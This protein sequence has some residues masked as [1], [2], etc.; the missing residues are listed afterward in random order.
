MC[1]I[2]KETLEQGSFG[3]STGLE[4]APGSYAQTLELIELSKTVAQLNGIYATH[5]RDEG[6]RLIEAVDE[7]LTIGRDAKVSVQISHLK[8]CNKPYWNKIDTVLENIQKANEAGIQVRADRYPY[9][10]YS[11]GLSAFL[12]LWSRQGTNDEILA[13]LTKNGDAVKIAEYA[14]SRSESIGGWDRILISNCHTDEG[15]QWEGKTILDGIDQTG[16]APFEFIRALLLQERLRVSIVGFAMSE[17]NLKK[18]L[19]Y[20]LMMIGSDGNAIAPYGLLGEGKPHPRSYGTFARVLGKYCREEQL[21]DIATAVRKMTSMPA[22]KIGLKQRGVIQKNYFADITIFNPDTVI[23]N[24]TY[25]N[26]HQ[27]ASGIEY[28]IV[29]G[30]IAILK[31]EHTGTTAGIVLRRG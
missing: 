10:A 13:R 1:R 26:P 5:M 2:L 8:T 11:T 17:D 18:F 27:Y 19:S 7:A 25:I 15:K 24:A 31:G 4:Y 3:L 21:F 28:V 30:K 29:S 20:P 16:L 12:P 9:I 14:Q 22:Q 23:D 6:E